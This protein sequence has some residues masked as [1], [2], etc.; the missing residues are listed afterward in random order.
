M[1][2]FKASQV[3]LLLLLLSHF[4]FGQMPSRTPT[5]NDNLKPSEVLSNGDVIYTI[6]H[7]NSLTH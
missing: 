7:Q 6:L 5:P 4:A 2:T 1:K 3:I